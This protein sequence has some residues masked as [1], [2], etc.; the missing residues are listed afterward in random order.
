LFITDDGLQAD[1]VRLTPREVCSPQTVGKNGG[2]W[3]PFGRG[4]DQ[5]GDQQEDDARSLVFET[6]PLMTRMEVL[7]APVVTLDVAADRPLA[8]LAVRLCDVRP[9]ATSLRVSFGILNLAHRDGHEAPTPLVPGQR[10]QVRIL[11]NDAGAVFPAGHKIRVAL[12]TSY[13]PMIWPSPER[14]TVTVFGGFVEFPVRTPAAADAL[15]PPL[16]GPET[17]P[18]EPTTEVREG[19]VRIDRLGL[20]VS[21]ESHFNSNINDDDP[22]SAVV[23]MR[24]SQVISRGAWRIRIETEMEM[25]CDHDAF[26]LQ[27]TMRA[28][29]GDMEVCRRGWDYSVPRNFA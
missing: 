28:F 2:A 21:S 1:S 24:Q 10:Y 27:A 18:P 19:V 9:D 12:S 4:G 25:S 14:A 6:A 16:S 20:E 5:A 22:L 29:E 11:L 26:L 23:K 17:A 15:L 3:C 13:W 8:N 7:G